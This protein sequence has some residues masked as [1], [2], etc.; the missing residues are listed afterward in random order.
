MGRVF[1]FLGL[2][3]VV[4]LATAATRPA[5][6]VVRERAGLAVAPDLACYIRA[7]TDVFDDAEACSLPS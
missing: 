6:A 3:V 4:V 1:R 2:A 7:L 5:A